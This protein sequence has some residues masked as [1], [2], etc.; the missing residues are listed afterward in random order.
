[1]EVGRV[2]GIERGLVVYFVVVGLMNIGVEF[3]EMESENRTGQAMSGSVYTGECRPLAVRFLIT[4]FLW[5]PIVV[6]ICQIR[7]TKRDM[8]AISDPFRHRSVA[9]CDVGRSLRCRPSGPRGRPCVHV[10]R[11]RRCFGIRQSRT[12]SLCFGRD[13]GVS[14]IA[15]AW[16]RGF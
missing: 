1:M 13:Q 8:K 16:N 4:S 7:S 9:C 11:L 6:V 5:W 10:R 15:G 12:Y 2:K 3:S 14:S